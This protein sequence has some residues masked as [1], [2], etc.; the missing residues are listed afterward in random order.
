MKNSSVTMTSALVLVPFCASPVPCGGAA[1]A[2]FCAMFAML[3]S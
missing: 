2:G 1:G 3:V